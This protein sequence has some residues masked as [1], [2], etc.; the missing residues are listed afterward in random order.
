MKPKAIVRK[1]R[2]KGTILLLGTL[3]MLFIIP[4]IGLAID[5]G[6]LYAAKSK[7]Q[8]AVDGAALAAARAL[9][10]GQD[11]N[12]QSAAAKSNAVNWF[13]SNFPNGY[14]GTQ[15][16]V[17]STTNVQVF[18]DPNN[19]HIRNVTIAA[20]TQVSAFFMRWLGYTFTTVAASGNA[21]RR[22]IVVMMVLDRSGSMGPVC[23]NLIS[24]AKLFTGQ[25]SAGRDNVGLISFADNT[26][27]QSSPTTNFQTV[28]GY[29]NSS[30]TATGAI[31]AI[32]CNGSTGTAQAL[33]LAH[34]E[35]IKMN[36]P[37]ALNVI[38]F[39]TD[40]LPNTITY[41]F[42]D[43][44]TSASAISATSNCRDVAGRKKSVGGFTNA[45]ASLVPWSG[46]FT[47]GTSGYAVGYRDIPAGTVGAIGTSDPSGGT[48]FML[49]DPFGSGVSSTNNSNYA[50]TTDAP[51]CAFPAYGSNQTS[52][53]AP[54]DFAWLPA[55][56]AF[57]NQLVP[58]NAYNNT[59]SLSSG[60][61][62]WT[63][64]SNY[65]DAAEN[66]A[67]N[68]AYRARS[69]MGQPST[70]GIGPVAYFVIGLGG[71]G[72]V[73]HVLLQRI[74]NDSNGDLYN[75]PTNYLPCA[76]ET[77]SNCATYPAQPPGTY[78]YALDKTKL[79]EAFQVLASQILRLSK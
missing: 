26:V 74:A 64:G 7:L 17:M 14:F 66:A 49:Y 31:D 13:Y 24:A 41:N 73:D 11:T 23:G 72:G 35:L 46:G 5:V 52:S 27:I 16:T 78:Y 45:A 55:T 69:N 6:F 2:S 21:S 70:T 43:A 8:S 37:G 3:S 42:W 32:K 65:H 58:S 59:V 51:G 75:T 44:A 57:G 39:E 29:T 67:D 50:S 68:A 10:L 34:N 77:A 1:H 19:A 79:T 15:G 38:L 47:T 30:G 76:Q 25:L 36:L 20:T 9:V 56:D 54:G 60:H 48:Y 40:G 63:N 4:M 18:D 28:L 22:D 71:N 33:S 61:V 53:S 12:A 62:P